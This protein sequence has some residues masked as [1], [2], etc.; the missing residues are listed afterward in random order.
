MIDIH[1]YI[2]STILCIPVEHYLLSRLPTPLYQLLTFGRIAMFM[3]SPLSL[4]MGQQANIGLTTLPWI[5][6]PWCEL[7]G[8]T[9]IVVKTCLIFSER[10]VLRGI[11]KRTSDMYS[12]C[13]TS[14]YINVYIPL[15]LCIHKLSATYNVS[16]L[17][18]LFD[19]SA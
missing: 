12:S 13:S 9:S 19:L 1:Q 11:S 5:L 18:S 10:G 3:D 17:S 7:F 6:I 8:G 4:R 2:Y 15:G 16:H 14:A